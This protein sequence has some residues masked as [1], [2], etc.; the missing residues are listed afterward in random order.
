VPSI[1]AV[2]RYG[3]FEGR[4]RHF[5]YAFLFLVLTLVLLGA[6][7]RATR[8]ETLDCTRQAPA[9]VSCE[10]RLIF[11]LSVYVAREDLVGVREAHYK[12]EI[13]SKGHD[14]VGGHTDILYQNNRT[15]S[16]GSTSVQEA[17]R[18]TQRM[19]LFLD[20]GGGPSIHIEVPPSGLRVAG[21]G[22]AGLAALVLTIAVFRRGFRDLGAYRFEVHDARD[23]S[24]D[25]ADGYRA[26]GRN[27][28]GELRLRIVRTLLGIPIGSREIAIPDDVTEIAI[29]RGPAP[30]WFLARGQEPPIGGRLVF[31]TAIGGT[32]PI[33]SE[34][35]RGDREHER[36][37][38]GLAKAL[39]L[40]AA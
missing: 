23:G 32:L 11:P 9:M 36:A 7:A 10:I 12:D 5:F 25:T 40:P 8:T 34:L 21:V 24:L 37:R 20:G 19:S 31:K 3:P 35:R 22:L 38:V 14:V 17:G 18:N 30:A 4:F 33:T 1:A 27:A 16:F 26:L 13:S 29:E 39:G 15:T 6:T 2:I 28:S